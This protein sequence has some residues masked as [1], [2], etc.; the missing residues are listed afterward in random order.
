MSAQP[1]DPALDVAQ[2]RLE[3]WF[4]TQGY[5]PLPHQRA[6]WKAYLQGR[7]GLLHTPTGSG[8]TLA[9]AGGP[10]L[11]A[12]A[13]SDRGDAPRLLWITP[14]RALAADTARA[15]QQ[16]LD[17]LALGWQV[18]LRTGD[19]SARDKRLARSGKREVVVTTPESL[20]LLLSYADTQASLGALRAVVVD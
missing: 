20:S 6:V 17:G 14:L 11:E 13:E 4:E 19:A 3:G 12:L 7:S 16:V 9:V 2:A 8:K 10:L 1:V 5:A 18:V 15:L